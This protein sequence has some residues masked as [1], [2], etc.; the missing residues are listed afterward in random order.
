[1]LMV[2]KMVEVGETRKALY[3]CQHYIIHKRTEALGIFE[4]TP[5]CAPLAIKLRQ[6]YN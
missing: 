5:G 2:N 3:F 6:Y 4:E 1:M